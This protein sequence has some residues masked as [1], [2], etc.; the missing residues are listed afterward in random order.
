MLDEFK[1]KPRSQ[2]LIHRLG[3][4]V[5]DV[6]NS[7]PPHDGESYDDW[8]R[9]TGAIYKAAQPNPEP[10]KVH[11][12][13]PRKVRGYYTGKDGRQYREYIGYGG[14]V[15]N[16]LVRDHWYDQGYDMDGGE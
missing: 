5:E 1:S 14:R 7:N 6:M 13:K 10:K 3:A 8:M 15:I 12:P 4:V 9:R 11:K 2:N 16:E